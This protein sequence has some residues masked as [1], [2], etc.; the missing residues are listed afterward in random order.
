MCYQPVLEPQ[1]YLLANGT[2]GLKLSVVLEQPIR[3][4][5]AGSTNDEG[6]HLQ[7]MNFKSEKKDADL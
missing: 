3:V 6:G 1:I 5:S 4:D 2:G 7:L